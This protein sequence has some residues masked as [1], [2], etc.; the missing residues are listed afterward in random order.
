MYTIPRIWREEKSRYNLIGSR[1]KKCGS[2]Y[3]PRRSICPKCK[4]K[5]MEDFEL[6]RVGKIFSFTIIRA[7]PRG[8]TEYTPYAIGIVELE[9]GVRIMA[10]IVDT[11]FE[12]I[13]IGQKV[14]MVFRRL[15]VEGDAGPIIYGHKAVVVK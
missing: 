15:M 8:F 7:A 10:Q 14:K 13:K 3:Y 12:N 4:S 2:K 11:D 5:E 9:D 1:D 6:P